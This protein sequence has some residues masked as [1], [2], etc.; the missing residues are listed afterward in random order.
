M[1]PRKSIIFYTDD[2]LDPKIANAVQTQLNTIGLP[3]VSVS[4]KEMTK[5]RGMGYILDL[6]RG[7]LTMFKQILTALNASKSDIIY[8]CE[9]DVLYPKEHFDFIPPDYDKFYYDLN[10]WKVREDG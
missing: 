10:W 6:E 1:S 2:R 3:M 5:L 8:F 9:H 7:Y 4:L